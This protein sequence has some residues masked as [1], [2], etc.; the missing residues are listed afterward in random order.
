M[1][2]AR[3]RPRQWKIPALIL[4][5]VAI[6]A[7]FLL[8]RKEDAVEVRF[9][10]ASFQDINR[11]VTTNG[12]VVP[13]NEFQARANFPG[14]VEKVFV[15]LGDKVKPGQMLVT[16]KDPFAA[17]R[18]S[19]TDASLQAARVADQNIHQGGSQE[20]RIAL[21]GDLVHAQLA[22]AQAAKTLAA[23]KQ[24]QQQGASSQAEVDAAQQQLD[25]AN[26]TLQ[27]L[28]QRSTG[29]YSAGDIS[30]AE[31]RVI[32][33]QESV[34]SAKVQFDNANIS[35]PL[36]GTVYAIQVSAYD[37]VPMGADLIR[38]ADLND[39]KIRA[40]FDEPEIGKLM[41][42]QSVTITWDGKPGRVWHGHIKQAPVAAVALGARSVG[43]CTITVDD[44]K[45]DLLPNTNVIVTV[46]IQQHFHVLTVPRGALHTEGSA[47]Y[48]YR[49]ADGRLHR[50]PV[51]VGIVNL[52][53]VEVARGLAENDIVAL[54]A[55]DS[56]DLADN[57]PVTLARATYSGP[58]MIDHILEHMR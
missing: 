51:D 25:A 9:G 39:T 58:G 56:R 47:N 28:R 31:A 57:L 21:Q 35:S 37:F 10:T 20:D 54:N 8:S 14:I 48:V 46:M 36:A 23:R 22:Q 15:E 12:T 19:G 29:R 43:E 55:I 17:E 24:L 3:V 27:T 40:Y 16:M 7:V 34:K 32:D 1:T 11:L 45:E 52:D 26:A 30:S 38:V 42:G 44:A 53:R 18:I 2:P 50:A 5:A 33:A 49:V 6:V 41:A 13:T 4:A